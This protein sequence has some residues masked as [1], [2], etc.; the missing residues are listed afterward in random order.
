MIKEKLPKIIED[1]VRAVNVEAL[2]VAKKSS[3]LPL[4][5]PGDSAF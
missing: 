5:Q 1:F 3:K 2:C 4:S